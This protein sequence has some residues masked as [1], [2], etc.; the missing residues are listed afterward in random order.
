MKELKAGRCFGVMTCGSESWKPY[1]TASALCALSRRVFESI[2][3]VGE[4]TRVGVRR[5][6]WVFTGQQVD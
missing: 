2:E 5:V 4:H 6:V 1:G 3:E